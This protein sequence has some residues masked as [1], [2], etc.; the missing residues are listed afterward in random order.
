MAIMDMA[1]AEKTSNCQL[2][3]SRLIVLSFIAVQ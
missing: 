1:M 3:S 2:K